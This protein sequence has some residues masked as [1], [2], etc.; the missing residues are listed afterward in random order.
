M[1]RNNSILA[2][3]HTHSRQNKKS[4]MFWATNTHKGK[5]V[6][7]LS[8]VTLL[9]CQI[10]RLLEHV[11]V[12][13]WDMC[14]NRCNRD[15][16]SHVQWIFTVGHATPTLISGTMLCSWSWLPWAFTKPLSSRNVIGRFFWSFQLLATHHR[17]STQPY[18]LCWKRQGTWCSV[19][20]TTRRCNWLKHRCSS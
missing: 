14:L 16:T 12:H 8:A 1:L 20:M 4:A 3:A 7:R 15:S 17:S 18:L 10:A 19:A 13:H 9:L 11:W 6:S 2:W 5:N